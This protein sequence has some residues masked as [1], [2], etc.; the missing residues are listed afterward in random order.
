MLQIKSF[1]QKYTAQLQQRRAGFTLVELLVVTSLV[2]LLLMTVSAMFM[3]FLVS[4]A[5]TN[6][7][8]QIKAEGNQMIAQV[9]FLFRSAKSVTRI[10]ADGS[11]ESV[12]PCTSASGSSETLSSTNLKIVDADSNVY[13]M[14]FNDTE[15]RIYIK[16]SGV[17]N[18]LNSTYVV[19]G[20]PNITCFGSSTNAKKSIKIDFT[21]QWEAESTFQENFNTTVQL[22]N[23]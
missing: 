22:R 18:A 9:E 5:Q 13:I 3:T 21:L 12:F 17:D 1:M 8:R 15:D 19:P 7:R 10:N 23:S 11:I 2:I 4:N 20:A 6:I 16:N 14:S